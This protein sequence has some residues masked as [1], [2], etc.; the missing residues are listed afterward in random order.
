MAR[1]GKA[2]FI[3]AV[4]EKTDLHKKHV[5]EAY[6]CMCEAIR[7]LIADGHEVTLEGVGRFAPQI[8]EAHEA[9]NPATGGAVK[10]PARL[11]M[12]FKINNNFKTALWELNVKKIEGLAGPENSKKESKHSDAKNTRRR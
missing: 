9:R 2:D 5:Q 11:Q 3:K 1:I 7:E 4:A 12:K 10:V 6:E 8:K